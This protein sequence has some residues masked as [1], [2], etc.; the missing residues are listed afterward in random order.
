[1]RYTLTLL[2]QHRDRLLRH[3]H[4]DQNERVAVILCGRSRLRDPWAEKFEERF[5]SREVIEVSDSYIDHHDR[6]HVRV[7]TTP[8]YQLAKR[9][10]LEGLAVAFIHSHPQSVTHFSV[11]DDE[12]EPELFEM[13]FNRT[14]TDRPHLALIMTPDGE[15]V[16]RAWDH[17]LKYHD[18]DMVRIIGKRFAFRYSGRGAGTPAHAFDRQVLA[19]GREFTQDLRVLRIG[20]VGC[21]GTGSA[22]AMLL[23]RAGIGHLALY[24]ADIVDFTNLN[25]L[26]GAR[27]ADADA[28]ALKVDVVGRA[29]SELGLGCQVRRFPMWIGDAGARDSLKSCDVI[30]G[31]TD[32]HAGRSVLNRLAY[33]YSLPV[34]DMGVLLERSDLGSSEEFRTMDGRVTVLGPNNTCLACRGLLDPDRVRAEDLKRNNPN[35]YERERALGYLPREGEPNPVVVTFTTETAAMAVNELFQRLLGFRG[36]EGSWSERVRQFHVPKDHDIHAAG[37]PREGCKL[38]GNHHYVGRGDMERF[39]DQA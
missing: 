23:A 19:F 6:T 33:F 4:Q 27:Q 15:V 12:N 21:G 30:F 18:L 31:C 17:Q 28:G 3:L 39:L 14:D 25:R 24:D 36:S 16:G 1:M 9:A 2:E 26:H 38:C 29:I 35:Q 32:D 20:I 34:I 37:R 22:I 13:V 11:R 10:A 5:V 7:S 8:I